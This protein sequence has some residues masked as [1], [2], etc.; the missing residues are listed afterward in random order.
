LE[1][2][3]YASGASCVVGVD[4]AGRGALAGPVVAAAVAFPPHLCPHGLVDSKKLTPEK[5]AKLFELILQDASSV[6]VGVIGPSRIDAINILRASHE[7]M[8]RAL[9]A[10]AQPV[11]IALI[12]GLAVPSLPCPHV[13]IVRGDGK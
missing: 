4:E 1:L 12:D 6:S 11:C 13:P 2:R 9:D 8:R 5:R 10:V 7:A 3:H